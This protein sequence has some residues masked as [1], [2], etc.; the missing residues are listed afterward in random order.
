MVTPRSAIK[1]PASAGPFRVLVLLLA[2]S[3]LLSGCKVGGG[4]KE[5]E[6]ERGMPKG[7]A[8]KPEPLTEPGATGTTLPGQ[9]GSTTP[10]QPGTTVAGSTQTTS[11]DVGTPGTT[12]PP[13]P[14]RTLATVPD[15]TGDPSGLQRKPAYADLTT[16]RVEDDGAQARFTVELAAPMPS[17]LG[18]DEVMGIGVDLFRGDGRESDYQVF[19]DGASEGWLAYF[20]DDKGFHKFPGTFQL[21][22]NKLVFTLPWSVLGGRQAG[23]V[24]AF[25]DW[26]SG[27][28]IALAPATSDKAPDRD[29]T[30][31]SP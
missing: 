3:L 20:S 4:K 27:D 2:A 29:T 13:R 22:G 21:G 23:S 17:P 30:P 28:A 6:T 14:F 19:A 1:G 9:T 24:S 7:L 10:G 8:A 11:G 16:V 15:A 31:F 12:V 5:A 18:P 25:C 26:T